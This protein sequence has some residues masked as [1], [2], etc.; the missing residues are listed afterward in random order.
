VSIDTEPVEVIV[1]NDIPVPAETL[2]T[3]VAEAAAQKGA[4]VVLADRT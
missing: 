1:V 2:V 3:P 4:P